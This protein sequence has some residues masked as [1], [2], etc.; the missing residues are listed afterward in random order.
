[1]VKAI[2]AEE[3]TNSDAERLL[4]DLKDRL[5]TEEAAIED[6]F[7]AGAMV[8]RICLALGL[9]PDW[10]RWEGHGWAEEYAGLAATRGLGPAKV[11][12]QWR[13]PP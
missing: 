12:A 2:E 7:F 5:D 11:V 3:R 10:S 13:P 9:K 1:M 8:D 4:A 6:N